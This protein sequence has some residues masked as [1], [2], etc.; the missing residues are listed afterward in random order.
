[1]TF[2]RSQTI[3]NPFSPIIITPKTQNTKN[4]SNRL[5][6]PGGYSSP[7]GSSSRKTQKWVSVLRHLAAETLSPGGSPSGTQYYTKYDVSPGGCSLVR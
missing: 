6:S 5:T 7:P 4:K 2:I 1:M 3:R